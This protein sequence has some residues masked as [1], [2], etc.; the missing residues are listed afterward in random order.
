VWE[1]A[2]LGNANLFILDE[3]SAIDL[4]FDSLD[5]RRFVFLAE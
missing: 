1:K 5:E 2:W 3:L 4:L